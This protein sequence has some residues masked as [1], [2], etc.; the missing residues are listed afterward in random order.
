MFMWVFNLAGPTTGTW[1]WVIDGKYYLLGYYQ[2]DFQ[3]H[4]TF[5]RELGGI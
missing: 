3:M 1:D 4:A 2:N 5:S